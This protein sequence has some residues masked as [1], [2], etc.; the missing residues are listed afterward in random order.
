MSFG[1]EVV[2]E[3]VINCDFCGAQEYCRSSDSDVRDSNGAKKAWR[4][5]GWSIGKKCVCP[6]CK[7]SRSKHE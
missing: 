3:Y 7:E 6:N 5:D 1:V 4:E 2:S